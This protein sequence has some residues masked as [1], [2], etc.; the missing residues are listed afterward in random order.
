MQ[1]EQVEFLRQ[2]ML[3]GYEEES[4]INSK[5]LHAVPAD[6]GDY[7]PD[8]KSMSALELSWHLAAADLWFLASIAAGEFLPMEQAMP[9]GVKTPADVAAYY[10]Q[11][12]S[13]SIAKVRQAPAEQ[14][15]K[16]MNFY[17]MYNMPGIMYMGFLSNHSIHHRGQLTVY[18]RPMGAKVP[19][20]YGGS[21][22]EPFQMPEAAG[23][24]A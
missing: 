20:I 8:P 17:N 18:L 10:D 9:E 22:D 23:A 6:K 7:R 11:R 21:A 5:V 15:A 16:P 24:S 2:I 12:V 3:Q 13:G 19:S 4:K 14:L 1:T